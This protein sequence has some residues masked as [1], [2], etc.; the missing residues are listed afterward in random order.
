MTDKE[1]AYEAGFDARLAGD[2]MKH[3]NARAEAAEAR[4]AVLVEKAVEA[5]ECVD[6]ILPLQGNKKVD[7]FAA[8]AAKI[9]IGQCA[10]AVR[11]ALST[12]A[13]EEER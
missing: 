13:G 9:V 7:E 6:W 2:A 4:V 10:R 11:A 8:A 1:R 3:A 12:G 5:V